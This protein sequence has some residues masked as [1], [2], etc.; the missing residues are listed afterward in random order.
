MKKE[1]I[2]VIGLG[3]VGL[4]TACILAGCKDTKSRNIFKVNGIDK[5]IDKIKKEIL[6]FDSKK[7]FFYEDKNLNKIFKNTISKNKINFSNKI[8][9]VSKSDIIIISVNFDFKNK[10]SSIKFKELK[11]L[12][13]QLGKVLKKK[14]MILIE[15]TLPPG[16]CDN[17]I[18]PALKKNLKKRKM[19]ME[20]IFFS[21]SYERVMPGKGYM[22]SIIN[23]YRCYAGMNQ[24]SAFKC[25]NFLKKYINYKKF[26]L[27]EFDNLIDCEAAKILENSYRAVNIAFIDEWT[28]FSIKTKLNLNK[29]IDAIK[30][31]STHN[32]IMRPGLGVGG[33]CL[34][35]D[36]DFIKFSSKHLFKNKFGFPITNIS[37]KINKKMIFS[38]VKFIKDKIKS[39]KNKK[40]LL[41]GAAYKDDV[42][43]TR[44]SPS[45][46][47]SN[48]LKKKRINFFFHDPITSANDNKKYSISNKLPKFE[49]FDLVLFCVKHTYYKKMN[50]KKFSKKPV[51]FDLNRVLSYSQV[52]HMIKNKF[53]LEILGGL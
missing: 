2:S 27:Y 39:F 13:Q 26:P 5:N 45:I 4:P 15:T 35:K 50:V 52:N 33:Y 31:R 18:I 53:K 21:Y 37:M 40:I 22:N 49:K 44:G 25:K 48:F 17:I 9:D 47:F 38:T 7:K 28:K 29:I 10:N 14:S 42:S 1:I 12:F 6:N 51:Y 23:N 20:D 36:P 19:K 34:T 3:F 16:T 11:N 43:D 8:K 32:N 41:L 46:L 24:S 30:Y